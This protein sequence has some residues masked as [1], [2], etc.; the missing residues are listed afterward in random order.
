[1][2]RKKVP[3]VIVRSFSPSFCETLNEMLV[4][5]GFTGIET[6]EWDGLLD[7]DVEDVSKVYVVPVSQEN[8]PGRNLKPGFETIRKMP[9]LG[10]IQDHEKNFDID[11]LKYCNEI[12]CWPCSDNEFALRLERLCAMGGMTPDVTRDTCL[13]EDFIDLNLVGSSPPFLHVLK[14][15]KKIARC[16]APVLIEGETGTGKEMA[17][18]AIHYMSRRRDFPFIPVNCGAIPDN[19]LENELFGHE[20]GAYTDAKWA[21]RGLINQAER[22]TIF[23]DEVEAF[24]P[25]GQ[26]VLLRFLDDQVFK[27][28]GSE[29]SRQANVRILSASNTKLLDMVSKGEFRRDLLYRLDI[30]SIE[31]P[32]LSQREGD[33]ELLAGHF[34][35][36][37]RLQYNRPDKYLDP[38][39]IRWMKGHSWPGN[40]RE[41]EN[42]INREFFLADGPSIKMSQEIIP[43]KDRRK[44]ILD[45]RQ[46][47][48]LGYSF[49][50]A[51][52]KII[53]QFEKK[54]LTW[55]I[56]ESDGN[57]TRAAK[58]AGKERRTLGKLLKKHN[59]PKTAA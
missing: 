32:P 34:L 17:A 18:R 44:T 11:F 13:L 51:K 30:L 53:D 28:L 16:D 46:N 35:N 45:R 15:V 3:I 24:S 6:M 31:M 4:R 38:E 57:V 27:P 26:F 50:E 56:T 20:K 25:K 58:R 8:D 41:L 37:Y 10:V 59:I 21:Q 9:V 40:V 48:F 47:L 54:Y 36:K 14:Q 19:L 1:M 43:Q 2:D 5:I 39:M 7:A 55:L 49:S 22:G 12:L 29:Q 52:K 33:I 23:F 42:M